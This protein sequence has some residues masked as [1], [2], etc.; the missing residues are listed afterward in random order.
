MTKDDKNT[1]K[2]K[3]GY[4]EE[5]VTK[6]STESWEQRKLRIRK[7]IEERRLGREEMTPYYRL[8]QSKSIME[9]V[10]RK[11]KELENEA[12]AQDIELKKKTL[13]RLFVFLAVETFIIFAFTFFQGIKWPFAFHLEEWSF[14]LLVA[15]TITQITSMLA[16]AVKHLFPNR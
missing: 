3:E 10:E 8:H 16:I 11:K 5:G 6:V 7:L 14:K 2:I 12:L 9:S 15:A 4:S 13:N 1:N